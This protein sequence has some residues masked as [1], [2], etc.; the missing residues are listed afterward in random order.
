MRFSKEKNISKVNDIFFDFFLEDFK[1]SFQISFKNWGG[2]GD[3][4]WG[5]SPNVS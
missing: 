1:R 2:W 3:F 5:E 4:F